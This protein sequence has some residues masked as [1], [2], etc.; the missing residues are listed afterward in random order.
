MSKKITSALVTLVLAVIVIQFMVAAIQPY[1]TWIGRTAALVIIVLMILAVIASVI[2]LIRLL[3][4]RFGGGG[5]FN[6]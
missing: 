1:L 4:N 2:L 3:V 5:T 6:G